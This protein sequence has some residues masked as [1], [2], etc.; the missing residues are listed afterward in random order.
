MCWM[1]VVSILALIVSCKDTSDSINGTYSRLID[2]E[3]ATGNDTLII[4]Q[5][6]DVTYRIEKRSKYK[7]IINGKVMEPES[8]RTKWTAI[9]DAGNQLLRETN[10]GKVLLLSE[11]SDRVILGALEYERVK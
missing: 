10:Q 8:H 6:N 9:Y 7:R 2:H 11:D 4:Q 3:F 5:V 1:W